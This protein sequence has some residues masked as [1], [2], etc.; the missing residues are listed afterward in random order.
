MY[1][2]LSNSK[3]KGY[4]ILHHYF[5][6][7]FS[8]FNMLNAFYAKKNMTKKLK[9]GVFCAYTPTACFVSYI[10]F[11]NSTKAYFTHFSSKIEKNCSFSKLSSLK[12]Q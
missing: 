10:T 8:S 2:E 7:F 12:Q 1:H 9:C 5:P 11:I 6:T 3:G 4:I